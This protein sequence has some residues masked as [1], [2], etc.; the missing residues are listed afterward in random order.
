MWVLRRAKR[1]EV[2]ALNLPAVAIGWGPFLAALQALQEQNSLRREDYWIVS[3]I[4]AKDRRLV[5]TIKSVR[6]I[7]TR[8]DD[9]GQAPRVG[10]G[11]KGGAARS[12]PKLKAY[13]R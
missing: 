6:N 4:M 3:K 5:L 9:L 2:D 7:E 1:D 13:S 12:K 10:Q 8:E 11:A